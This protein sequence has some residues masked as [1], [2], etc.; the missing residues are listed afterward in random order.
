MALT[1]AQVIAAANRGVF[2]K[3]SKTKRTSSSTSKTKRTSSPGNI[4]EPVWAGERTHPDDPRNVD[5]PVPVKDPPPVNPD[6]IWSGPSESRPPAFMAQPGKQK[7]TARQD[8]IVRLPG[9]TLG[10]QSFSLTTRTSEQKAAE[11]RQN[12]GQFLLGDSRSQ[13]TSSSPR[14]TATRVLQPNDPRR[15]P[16]PTAQPND[17]RRGNPTSTPVTGTPDTLP[18]TPI[19]TGPTSTPVIRTPDPVVRTPESVIRTPDPVRP[20]VT[21][22]GNLPGA[23]DPDRIPPTTVTPEPDSV[24]DENVFAVLTQLLNRYGI[25]GLSSWVRGLVINEASAAEITVQLFQRQEF[26]DRFPAIAAIDAD[27]Q[28]GITRPNISP[29]DYMNLEQ[30]YFELLSRVDL[31]GVF[32]TRDRVANWIVEGVSPAEVSRRV[33]N[34]FSKMSLTSE[35]TKD[36]FGTFF[37]VSGNQALAAYMLDSNNLEDVLMRQVQVAEI[38]GRANIQ[39]VGIG[40]VGAER[41]A[42]LGITAQQASSGFTNINRR[43]GL[44]NESASEGIDFTKE[45]RGVDQQF[46]LD[47]GEAGQDLDRRLA[48]RTAAFRG[49]GGAFLGQRTTGFGSA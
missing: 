37:G 40:Q 17:P 25:G 29:E 19:W 48:G 26:K 22:P 36:A 33:T 47:Q 20:E 7:P 6:D 14:S 44:F 13:P 5:P 30:D 39:G 46:G 32:F 12:D 24:F 8:P 38:G 15:S 11:A 10:N 9:S 35:A 16:V 45:G 31:D 49:G 18:I 21:S 1:F 28:G 41:F 4:I 3:T 43:G 23:P 27:N 42:T 34:G 2:S